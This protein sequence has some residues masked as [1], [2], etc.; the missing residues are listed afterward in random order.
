V[1]E[2]EFTARAQEATS[3]VLKGYELLKECA[4]DIGDPELVDLIQ[5]H[6]EGFSEI[7]K[8]LKPQ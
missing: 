8:V 5:K 2:A 6:I 4:Q 1:N 3:Y 7:T